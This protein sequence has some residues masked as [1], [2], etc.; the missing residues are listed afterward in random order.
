M[1]LV[2]AGADCLPSGIEATP[3]RMELQ[4]EAIE[5]LK[6]DVAES[7]MGQ[8]ACYLKYMVRLLIAL[9]L[10]QFIWCPPEVLVIWVVVF[11]AR[12]AS[13]KSIVNYLKGWRYFL[14]LSGYDAKHWSEWPTLRRVLQGIKRVKGNCSKPKLPLDPGLMLKCAKCLPGDGVG[15]ALWCAMLVGFFGF[16][17]KCHLCVDGIC[18]GDV[19]LAVL[20][21]KSFRFDCVNIV[22]M[23]MFA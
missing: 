4:Q 18:M 20:R 23:L 22:C 8:Y 7:T 21:R 2:T 10:T 16:L 9:E 13:Y 1:M 14:A 5:Y 12:S 19:S 15:L 17:R 3:V 11:F 6:F